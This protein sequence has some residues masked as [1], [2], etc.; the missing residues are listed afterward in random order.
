[1]S[2]RDLRKSRNYKF[3]AKTQHG[4]KEFMLCELR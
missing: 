3:Y 2:K 1:M 4:V